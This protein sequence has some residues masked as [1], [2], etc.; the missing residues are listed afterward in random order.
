MAGYVQLSR[1]LRNADAGVLP[2][3]NKLSSTN[4][5]AAIS[6]IAID[7]LGDASPVAPHG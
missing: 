5:A 7:L 2:F 6:S 3:L 1:S 4:I